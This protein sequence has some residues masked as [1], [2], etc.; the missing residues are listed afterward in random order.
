MRS[1]CT[2]RSPYINAIESQSSLSAFTCLQRLDLGKMVDL[3]S[4]AVQH[5]PGLLALLALSPTPSLIPL[6]LLVTSLHLQAFPHGIAQLVLLAT[7]ASI[8]HLGPSLHALS[9]PAVSVVALSFFSLLSSSV[10]FTTFTISY[11][12]AR[13]TCW[14]AVAYLSPVGRLI[15]WSPVVGL[16]PYEWIRPILG[17]YG[18][19][20]VVASWAVVCTHVISTWLMGSTEG[21]AVPS[22]YGDI[23]SFSSEEHRLQSHPPIRKSSSSRT[24]CA[25]IQAALLALLTLP[26][27]VTSPIPLSHLSPDAHL[28]RLDDYISET[29]SLQSSA[30]IILWPEGAVRFDTPEEKTAGLQHIQDKIGI[31][32]KYVGVSFSEFVPARAPDNTRKA[33]D[34]MNGLVLLG[35]DGPVLE[36]YKRMLVP[37]AE[38]FSMTPSSDPPEIYT[39]EL[40]RPSGWNKTEWAPGHNGIRPIPLTASICLDFS[41]SSSFDGITSRP[42]LILA[43]ARTWHTGVGYA[44]WSQA[45]ARAEETGSMVLWCDGGDGGLSGVAGGGMHEFVQV[46]QGSWSKTIGVQWPFDQR[47]T[48]FSRGGDGAALTIVWAILGVG[49]GVERAIRSGPSSIVG[50]VGYIGSMIA[51]WRLKKKRDEERPLLE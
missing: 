19:D 8:A 17:Q 42:A 3:A 28:S 49:W 31:Y 26:S 34:W 24:N 4:Y 46:G 36:Y 13:L 7:A 5:P 18:I 16:G 23:I 43:P 11:F 30:N 50:Y 47:R 10:A 25:F 9:S 40:P 2:M 20:W 35:P 21:D 29:K 33:G 12:G 32:K 44:M 38:S 14:G 39:M 41:S 27:F 6:I 48:L 15:T 51:G 37:V 45:R 22:E 1:F